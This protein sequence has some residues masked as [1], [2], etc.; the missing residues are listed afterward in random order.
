M[1]EILFIRLGFFHFVCA[2]WC[3]EG[4]EISWDFCWAHHVLFVVRMLDVQD[5]SVEAKAF[6]AF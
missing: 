6:E 5:A 1:R 3:D 4:M 2:W